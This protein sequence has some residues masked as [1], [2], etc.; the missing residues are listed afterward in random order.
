MCPQV[1]E[2]SLGESAAVYG[3]PGPWQTS[4]V[5]SPKVQVTEMGVAVAVT[6]S[7]GTAAVAVVGCHPAAEPDPGGESYQLV[8]A[9]RG[10]C[11]DLEAR[12]GELADRLLGEDGRAWEHGCGRPQNRWEAIRSRRWCS[13]PVRRRWRRSSRRSRRLA[14][15]R[16]CPRPVVGTLDPPCSS[17]R[18]SRATRNPG[19][20][21]GRYVQDCR[22]LGT[23]CFPQWWR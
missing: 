11:V 6:D 4:V 13:V 15:G 14:V 18:R 9:G 5:P 21:K 22:A 7:P 3:V 1:G 16:R 20:C 23:G 19:C 17:S 10:R 12:Q 2:G 8:G